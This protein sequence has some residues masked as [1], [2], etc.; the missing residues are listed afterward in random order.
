MAKNDGGPAFPRPYSANPNSG[1]QAWPQDGMTTRAYMA[2]AFLA[3]LLASDP[4]PGSIGTAA[5]DFAAD[6]VK[7]ADALLAELAK[8]E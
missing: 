6:A 8:E 2:T 3:G 5:G 7:L 1:E 4:V